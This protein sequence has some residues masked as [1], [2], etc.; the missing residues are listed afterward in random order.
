MFT[1]DK[2]AGMVGALA[3]VFPDA[4]YQRCTVHFYRNV[5]SKVPKSKR[6]LVAGK[7]KAVHAQESFEAS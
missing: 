2:A 6:K 5:F 7:L 1:G 4:A 3:E